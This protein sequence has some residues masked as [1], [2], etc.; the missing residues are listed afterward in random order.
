MASEDMSPERAALVR[1]CSRGELGGRCGGWF[2]GTH[3]PGE[4]PGTSSGA[5]AD[6]G[7]DGAREVVAM[8]GQISGVDSCALAAAA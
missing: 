5:R 6:G 8:P 2:A 7:G 3:L 4:M 1:S